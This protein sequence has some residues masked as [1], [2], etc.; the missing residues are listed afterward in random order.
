MAYSFTSIFK[1]EI[2]LKFEGVFGSFPGLGRVTI[3][4][5]N[6]EKEGKRQTQRRYWKL[7]VNMEIGVT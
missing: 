3:N 4:A 7:E 5:S 1:S 2:G 6:I